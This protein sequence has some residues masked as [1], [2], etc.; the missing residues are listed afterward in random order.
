[1]FVYINDVQCYLFIQCSILS[2]YYVLGV[3]LGIGNLVE[4]KIVLVFVQF[5][6]L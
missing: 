3:M 5:I 6:F 1:M 2:V 4:K